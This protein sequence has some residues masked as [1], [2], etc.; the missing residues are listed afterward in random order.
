MPGFLS[1]RRTLSPITKCCS[2]P[3]SGSGGGGDT[4][5]CG[6][7]GEPIDRHYGIYTTLY[8]VDYFHHTK[9]AIDQDRD[10]SLFCMSSFNFTSLNKLLH[11]EM[12]ERIPL[13]KVH[14][15]NGVINVGEVD[16]T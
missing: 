3:P 2:S 12:G 11:G 6:R 13:K 7:G 4:L 10:L 9:V 1:S 5:A 8:T 16:I 15:S 14:S